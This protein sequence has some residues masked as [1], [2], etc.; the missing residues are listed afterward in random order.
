M[1]KSG[2]MLG[3]VKDIGTLALLAG[4]AYL[5]YTYRANIKGFFDGLSG[6]A[7]AV[8]TAAEAPG[9]LGADIVDGLYHICG[10]KDAPPTQTKED[11]EKFVN[12]TGANRNIGDIV[13]GFSPADHTWQDFTLP[14]GKVIS[15]TIIGKLGSPSRLVGE[16]TVAAVPVVTD[17]WTS[18]SGALTGKNESAAPLQPLSA[19]SPEA[20]GIFTPDYDISR[21]Y[22]GNIGGVDVFSNVSAI[23][24]GANMT[25]VG[26]SGQMLSGNTSTILSYLGADPSIRPG[27]PE[28]ETRVLFGN[29]NLGSTVDPTPDGITRTGARADLGYYTDAFNAVG[30][31]LSGQTWR[32]DES[33]NV[34]FSNPDGGGTS[35]Y[36]GYDYS[37]DAITTQE[38]YRLHLI[39]MGL[40]TD[41]MDLRWTQFLADMSRMRRERRLAGY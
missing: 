41:D 30:V 39:K 21:Q 13:A 14:T 36:H 1:A 17:T 11:V 12:Q 22:A 3:D 8:K 6:A 37:L 23:L 20:N 32:S 38:Q 25:A 10:G 27:T 16:K 35:T 24:P 33:G 26:T 2:S 28:Y 29:A 15:T 4:G 19:G 5:V 34:W 18:I 9:K 40:P 31:A 7:D